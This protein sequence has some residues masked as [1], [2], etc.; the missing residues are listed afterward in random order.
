MAS[1]APVTPE[2]IALVRLHAKDLKS[3]S[4]QHEKS[5]PPY[6]GLVNQGA[7]CYL[8]RMGS[9]AGPWA[10]PLPLLHCRTEH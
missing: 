7:T 2:D 10:A 3:S 8:V 6:T 1:E 5:C 9:P 4:V